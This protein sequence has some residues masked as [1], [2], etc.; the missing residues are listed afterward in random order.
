M[1]EGLVEKGR[2]W[3]APLLRW[4]Q[5]PTFWLLLLSILIIIASIYS[6]AKPSLEPP[7]SP[8]DQHSLDYS[9]AVFCS[10]SDIL[11][12]TGCNHFASAAGKIYFI[13]FWGDKV[14]LS[15]TPSPA[16]PV[17]VAQNKSE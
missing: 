9:R 16:A 2:E 5:D 8:D 11:V 13:L 14:S 17:S 15:S 3:A 7:S 10:L 1:L 6:Q 12:S 4:C